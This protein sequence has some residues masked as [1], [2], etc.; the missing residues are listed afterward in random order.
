M[1]LGIDV[2]GTKTLI[3]VL[4]EHGVIKEKIKF[5]TPKDYREFLAEVRKS[6]STFEHQDY[7]A[8]GVGIPVSLFDRKKG[9]AINFSNLPW[10]NVKVAKDLRAILHCPIV[11]E[12]DAKLAALSESRLLND[13]YNKVLYVTISTGI[14][15]GLIV[16]NKID[17]NIGDDG[18]ASLMVEHQGKTIA[19]EK[20]ASGQAIFKKYGKKASEIEDQ[21]TWKTVSRN[22]AK[23]LVVLIS[24]TE[25]D[26]IVIG[27][28]V[29]SHFK[30]YGNLLESELKKYHLP[31]LEIPP[32]IGAERPEDAVIY[33]C[34]DYAKEKY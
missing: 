22:I 29:G 21:T 32:I 20:F 34:Y 30:K 6:I 11:I 4:D 26:I 16:N 17:P 1:Y 9:L 33:G 18:G 19:W 15:F 8:A 2:G 25:P 31:L 12:N 23:G 14:G 24:I 10:R 5:P 7:K 3:A 28:G 27:G 13:R